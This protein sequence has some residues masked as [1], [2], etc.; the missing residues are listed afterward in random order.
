MIVLAGAILGALIGGTLA[1]RR[2]GKTLD[3]A[4]YAFVYA[5]IFALLGLFLTLILHR[6]ALV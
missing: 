4:Q 5:I 1:A 6:A 3:I 2:K